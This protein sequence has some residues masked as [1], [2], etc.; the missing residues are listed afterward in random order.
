M[1]VYCKQEEKDNAYK[2]LAVS[3]NGWGPIFRTRAGHTYG[4]YEDGDS[5]LF[6]SKGE[7]IMAKTI[8]MEV[9][10]LII[11]EPIQSNVPNGGSAFFKVKLSNQ[12]YAQSGHYFKLSYK[13]DTNNKGAELTVDGM[14]L[15][16]G[17]KL[18]LPY[19]KTVEK[20]IELKQGDTSILDYNDIKL[21]LRSTTQDDASSHWPVIES[22]VP[23]SAHFVP[24]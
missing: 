20:V 8:Q 19:N 6:Y 7:E 5:T 10:Q 21:Y 13:P 16:E 2:Q 23:I 24:V 15:L 1:D 12:S 4:P 17:L 22:V 3:Y 9:P 11:D 18:Y 14:P